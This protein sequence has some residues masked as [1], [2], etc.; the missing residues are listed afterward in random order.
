MPTP[1]HKTYFIFLVVLFTSITG[2]F[3]QKSIEE[4]LERYNSG[5]IAYISAESLRSKLENNEKFVLLDSRSKEEYEVSHLRNAKWI[6]YKSFDKS[7]VD[8]IDNNTEIIIYCAVGVRSEK[9]GEE[10]KRLGFKNVKNLYGGIFLWHNKRFPIFAN[11]NSTEKI[12]TYN[13]RWGKFIN[14]GKKVN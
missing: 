3:G 9:I 13:K 4:T 2:L 5:S 1:N 6:G 7:K 8:S 12:H 10:L 14:H 11:G